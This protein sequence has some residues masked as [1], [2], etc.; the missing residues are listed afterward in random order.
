MTTLY[1]WSLSMLAPRPLAE[2]ARAFDQS[3]VALGKA[4]PQQL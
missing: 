1:A 2:A 4:Q 3:G